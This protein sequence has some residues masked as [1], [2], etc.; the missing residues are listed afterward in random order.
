MCCITGKAT[1]IL[2][3]LLTIALC[4]NAKSHHDILGDQAMLGAGWPGYCLHDIPNYVG[5]YVFHGQKMYIY[6]AQGSFYG[7]SHILGFPY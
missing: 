6:H 1:I 4:C 3:Y 7:N 5:K 2:Q